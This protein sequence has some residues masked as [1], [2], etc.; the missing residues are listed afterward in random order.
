M[1]RQAR[2]FARQNPALIRDKLPQQVC[3]LEIQGV[4]REIDLGLRTGR[5]GLPIGRT[6]ASATIGLFRASLARH[7]LII[8][9]FR[10]AAYGA[11]ERDCT[12]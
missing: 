10:G 3:V 5:A 7:K 11:A 2:V 6:A 8:T 12:F 9:L 1:R 4:H